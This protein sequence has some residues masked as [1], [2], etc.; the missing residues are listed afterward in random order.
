M[1]NNRVMSKLDKAL[2]LGTPIAFQRIFVDWVG[3]NINAALMLSQLL[4]WTKVVG[5]GVWIYKTR[6]DWWDELG[7]ARDK[8][9]RARGALKE[10][11]IIQE[12]RSGIPPKVYFRIKRSRFCE[13][14][15]RRE[16]HHT[17]GG[18]PATR[19]V[20]N[21]PNTSEITTEITTHPSSHARGMASREPVVG[22][23]NGEYTPP[24]KISKAVFEFAKWSERQG[25][26]QRSGRLVKGSTKKGWPPRTLGL[27]QSYHAN[28]VE[29]GIKPK[30]ILEVV[31][32]YIENKPKSGFIPAVRTFIRF[33]DEFDRIEDAI[34]RVKEKQN[35]NGDNVE[36]GECEDRGFTERERKEL[37]GLDE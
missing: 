23:F 33:R 28:L 8:Q 16:T 35:R 37:L 12:K 17:N 4:Y 19:M 32:W 11:G 34:K 30:R 9:E 3:G 5:W 7:I 31:R 20:G 1:P 26:H 21:Q 15:L 2:S 18:R 6:E 25:Y 22:F 36:D 14:L 13:L 29:S 10:A 27:W 24:V